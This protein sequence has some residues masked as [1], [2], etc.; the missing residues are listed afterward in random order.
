[1]DEK[2][3]VLTSS[4]IIENADK[5]FDLTI[6]LLGIL[7]ATLF[8]FLTWGLDPKTELYKSIAFTITF[9]APFLVSLGLWI[10]TRLE[11]DI[12]QNTIRYRILA[13]AVLNADYVFSMYI[14]VTFFWLK[15][16]NVLPLLLWTTILIISILV[17]NVIIP[18]NRIINMYKTATQ[19]YELWEKWYG[20]YLYEIMF[21]IMLVFL[22]GYLSYM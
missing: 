20:K 1:M 15:L 19:N 18:F 6:I 5:S 4:Q 22:A 10:R 9:I 7:Q 11:N 21:V 8:Q 13:W 17:V 2:S 14:F 3:Q 12:N 16:I